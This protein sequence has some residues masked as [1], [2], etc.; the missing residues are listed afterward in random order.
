[1]AYTKGGSIFPIHGGAY[2]F[3]LERFKPANGKKLDMGRTPLMF[4][5]F[6]FFAS[7][8]ISDPHV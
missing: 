6:C 2:N 3:M 8:G 7:P 5:Y 4:K 1:M